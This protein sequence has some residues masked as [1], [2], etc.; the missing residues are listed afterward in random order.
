MDALTEWMDDAF[1]PRGGVL[2][3]D[4]DGRYRL[5]VGGQDLPVLFGLRATKR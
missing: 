1:D 2:A 3:K 4:A 5:P